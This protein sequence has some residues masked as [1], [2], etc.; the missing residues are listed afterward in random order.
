[1]ARRAILAALAAFLCIGLP[2]VVRAAGVVK[3]KA[4]WG[5][6]ALPGVT[7]LFYASPEGGFRGAPAATAGPTGPD[8]A[9]EASLPAGKYYLLARKSA[10]PPGKPLSPGDFF[11]Y[12]GGNPVQA[13]EGDT[14]S[15]GVNCSRVGDPGERFR[16]GGPGIRGKVLDGEGNPVPRARV[17]L[18]ADGDTI[19]RGIGF[20]SVLAG[21]QGD[22]SFNLE[23]GSYYV[24]ARR[25]AEGDRMGPLGGGDLF[26][27]A[28]DNPV[29][30]RKDSYTHISVSAVA[31][32]AKVKEGAQEMTLDGTVKGGDTFI[33]G[34][35]RDRDGKP[36]A[37]VY[38]AAYRDAMMTQKPDFISKKTG[39][40]GVYTITLSGEGEYFIGARNTIGGPAE[41]GDLLGKYG[42]T[43]DHS[44]K[45]KAGE[46]LKGIDVVVEAV[47]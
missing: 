9:F 28:H 14:L 38:A 1:M 25:R 2:G 6:K 35:V 29:E 22:F 4:T 17:T 21:P 47:E 26:G 41:R 44:V 5:G 31:K 23:P 15:V 8:G 39:P 27:Y 11:A 42:G 45:V 40:D 34:V 37:G 19:F 36:V 16:P 18:Y 7:L 33:E 30:V 3:G 43:E 46:K 13:G 10:S 24:V 20:A 12:Y 32:L